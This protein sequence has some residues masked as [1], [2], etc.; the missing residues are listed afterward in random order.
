MDVQ[1]DFVRKYPRT[2]HLPQSPGATSDDK[3]AALETLQ[4]LASG[5][6]LVVTEKMDGGN[7]SLYRDF[8]HGRSMDSGTHS[9][10]TYARGVWAKIRF[11][12][13]EGFKLSCESMYARRSVAY[14]NLP[15]VLFLFAVWDDKSYSLNWD[16]VVEWGEL[17]GLPTPKVIYRGFNFE[18]A[19]K[20]WSEQFDE[21]TSEG[22][23]LRTVEGFSF[24]QFDQHVV[25]YVRKDHVRTSADW[26]HRD[27]FAVNTFQEF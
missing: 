25:K 8:F 24:E 16:E 17:L 1:P 4:F 23:V 19:V 11:E 13:P 12:I 5:V 15:H 22:F 18:D 2:P 3:W 20:A 6:E 14:D 21:K 10:D 27:D 7:L 26:R 9:W